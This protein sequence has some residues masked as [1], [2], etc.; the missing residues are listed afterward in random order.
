M[1]GVFSGHRVRPAR[2]VEQLANE[3]VQDRYV[4]RSER[5]R[6]G[7]SRPRETS[8]QAIIRT[9]RAVSTVER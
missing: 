5:T 6:P 2:R 4:L 1:E 9:M 8:F 7:R 3:R